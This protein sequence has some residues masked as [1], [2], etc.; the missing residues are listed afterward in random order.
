MVPTAAFLREENVGCDPT[1]GEMRRV[2]VA[3]QIAIKER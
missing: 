2:A 1:M 3:K